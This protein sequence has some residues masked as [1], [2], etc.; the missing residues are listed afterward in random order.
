MRYYSN[1]LKELYREKRRKRMAQY[2]QQ[3]KEGVKFASYTLLSYGFISW[4]I[5][6]YHTL[7]EYATYSL[8]ATA[9][10]TIYGA[11]QFPWESKRNRLVYQINKYFYK[12]KDPL[13]WKH[14]LDDAIVNSFM[15]EFLFRSM[16]TLLSLGKGEA[17]PI[18]INPKYGLRIYQT[19]DY[20][21]RFIGALQ[22]GAYA[23]SRP[24]IY[25]LFY[26][27]G[28]V[29]AFHGALWTLLT[30]Q[31]SVKGLLAAMVLHALDNIGRLYLIP[32]LGPQDEF[33]S[34]LE[35]I[36]PPIGQK[37]KKIAQ[38]RTVDESVE[39]L[40]ELK[41]ELRKVKWLLPHDHWL[42]REIEKV[43]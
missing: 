36:Y 40:E 35:E 43:I 33:L 27:V 17:T 18:E 28:T 14:Q 9:F 34:D 11:F 7:G 6:Q 4:L 1:R 23:H 32:R 25:P 16:S 19:T 12:K 42:R 26:E 5:P 38:A 31:H 21:L 22:G 8:I 41:Q 24:S 29:S 39:A 15:N 10:A 2:I 13:Y 3:F 20:P 37:L 30:Y